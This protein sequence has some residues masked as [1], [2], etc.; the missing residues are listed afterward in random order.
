MF[1]AQITLVGNVVEEIDLKFLPSGTAVAQFRLAATDHYQDRSTGEWK[2]GNTVFLTCTAWRQVAE[3]VAESL[4]KGTRVL[5]VG[6]LRQ[7]TYENAE[8]EKRT[9]YEVEVEEVGPSLR[10]ATAKVTKATRS[11]ATRSAGAAAAG[12]WT[13]GSDGTDEPPF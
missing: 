12:G 9:A 7:R 1:S 8:G 10:H 11:T 2:D 6:K 4:V 3:N 13:P 5:V